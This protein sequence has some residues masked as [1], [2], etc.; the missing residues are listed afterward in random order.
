MKISQLSQRTDVP[1]AT[2]KY[3]IR[4]G[5]LNPGEKT[6]PN[7]ATYGDSHLRRLELIRSLREGAGLGVAAIARTL[8][9]LDTPADRQV[10]RHV[11]TA[12]K[13]LEDA[14]LTKSEPKLR[15]RVEDVVAH[16]IDRMNWKVTDT[17]AGRA[18][19]EEAL[20]AIDEHW[21]EGYSADGLER[22]A[23]I[24]SQFAQ[25]EIPDDWSPGSDSLDSDKETSLAYA[26]LGTVLYEPVI[27]ALRRLAHADRHRQL[28]GQ[29]LSQSDGGRGWK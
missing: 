27:L 13:A 14:T 18:M 20:A 26:V 16:L 4:E 10:G 8:E 22:Y 9:A 29:A 12:L 21:P 11:G 6:A 24:A 19:L 2:I 17:S 25:L 3:Y 28:T 15:G 5:L 7:Q 1:V 23:E